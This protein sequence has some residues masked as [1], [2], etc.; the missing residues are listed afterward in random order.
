MQQR[1]I[2]SVLTFLSLTYISVGDRL[3]PYPYAQF[4]VDTRQKIEKFALG[5]FPN[6]E[7]SSNSERFWQQ[8]GRQYQGIEHNN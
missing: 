1:S 3:L 5:L 7:V 4:S 2:V 6:V 8:K